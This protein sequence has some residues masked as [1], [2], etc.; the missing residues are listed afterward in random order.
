[1]SPLRETSN[2]LT[3]DEPQ[4]LV[5]PLFEYPGA[6]IVLR[7]G[8]SHHFRIPRSYIVHC[9]PVLNDLIL[10]ALKSP[11][12][13]DVEA[14]LPVV[15]LPE[16]GGILHSL[17]TFIF[18]VTPL[19]PST[20]EKAMELLSVAQAYQ[21]ASVLAHIR[22]SIAR[23]NPPSTQRDTALHIY[24]LAQKH[25]L[26]Q[27]ALQAAQ[28]ILKYPMRSIEDFEDKLDMM[29]GAALFELWKY[30]EKVR[31]LLASDLTEIKASDAPGP[32]AG[33]R[34]TASGS[35]QIPPWLD[36]YIESIRDTPYV[37]DFIEFNTALARHTRDTHNCACASIP[38]KT[39]RNFWEALTS[40]FHG[41]L[42]EVSVIDLDELLTRLKPL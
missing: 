21:M 36:E 7:S 33:F 5:S 25:G 2:I 6:D 38:S 31:A 41:S 8:D 22:Y 16:S 37:F 4:A 20:A 12:N 39:I 26:H 40:V 18:P 14:S 32:L 30:Y 19:V 23:Q 3:S 13:A 28:I 10:N 17:L 9:S 35:S 42:E 34:C 1:M 15:Q 27:E 11:D 24:S 29:P